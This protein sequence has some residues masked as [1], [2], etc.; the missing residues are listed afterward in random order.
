MRESRK[1][2]KTHL[3]ADAYEEWI[4]SQVVKPAGERRQKK[5]SENQYES[6]VRKRVEKRLNKATRGRRARG[7]A[8]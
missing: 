6:W 8:T 2:E 5:V 3:P 7:T 4:G 1:T